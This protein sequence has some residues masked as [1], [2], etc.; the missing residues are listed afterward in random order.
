MAIR[1][2]DSN[3]YCE[4]DV[5]ILDLHCHYM[6]NTCP[7]SVIHIHKACCFGVKDLTLFDS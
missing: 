7:G 5:I 6:V 3:S 1:L 2:K 4:H